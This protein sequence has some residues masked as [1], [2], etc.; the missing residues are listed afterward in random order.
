MADK[1]PPGRRQLFGAALLKMNPALAA[2]A[3]ADPESLTELERTQLGFV[4]SADDPWTKELLATATDTFMLVGLALHVRFPIAKAGDFF[5]KYAKQVTGLEAAQFPLVSKMRS[6]LNIFRGTELETLYPE[7]VDAKRL[8]QVDWSGEAADAIKRWEKRM[9]RK[10]TTQ[11]EILLYADDVNDWLSTSDIRLRMTMPDYLRPLHK[12]LHRTMGRAWHETAQGQAGKVLEDLRQQGMDFDPS[13]RR[14]FMPRQKIRQIDDLVAEAGGH[15]ESSM[16][17][18]PAEIARREAGLKKHVAGGLRTRRHVLAPST[19]DLRAVQEHLHGNMSELERVAQ[20]GQE[21]GQYS[22]RAV[23][24][25]IPKYLHQMSKTNAFTTQ[26]YGKRVVDATKRVKESG[27]TNAALLGKMMDDTYIPL[28]KNEMT[29]GQA[30][31][32]QQWASTKA[33][34]VST[35]DRML[36]QGGWNKGP[37][38]SALKSIKN[39]LLHEEGLL[40]QAGSKL[41]GLWTTGALGGNVSAALQNLSSTALLA[42]QIGPTAAGHGIRQTMKKGEKYFRVRGKKGEWAAWQE[43]FPEFSKSGLATDP[44][45]GE[46][47]ELL[48]GAYQASNKMG[49]GLGTGVKGGLRRFQQAIMTPFSA[50]EVGQRLVAFEGSHWKALKDGL[51]GQG[52]RDFAKRMVYESQFTAGPVSSP[53]MFLN[54]PGP[55][56]HL[57]TYGAR[58]VE[59]LGASSA[60]ASGGKGALGPAWGP[61]EGRSFGNLG[62]L[63]MAT[64]LMEGTGRMAGQD[65]ERFGFSGSIPFREYGAFAPMPVP[66]M[67]SMLGSAFLDIQAGEFNQMKRQIS[68]F[69][70]G[71]AAASRALGMVSPKAAM[72]LDKEYTDWVP[73]QQG[74]YT[75]FDYAGRSRGQY[76]AF[77][78]MLRAAGLPVGDMDREQAARKM[79][80]AQRDRMKEMRKEYLRLSVTGD[81]GA[82]SKIGEDWE[83]AFGF[84]L[85]VRPQD[86]DTARMHMRM[87]RNE[88]L[89]GTMPRDVQPQMRRIIQLDAVNSAFHLQQRGVD[90]NLMNPSYFWSKP[91]TPQGWSPLGFQPQGGRPRTSQQQQGSF[92]LSDTFAL[93]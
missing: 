35:I 19:D 24:R 75:L 88:S 16:G 90:P 57:M 31:W 39:S 58:F 8:K 65:W 89:I 72:A 11:D 15:F 32:A 63:A 53:Y 83:R 21:R 60:W 5:T 4:S 29:V 41:T 62:R 30:V 85:D 81:H 37:A 43:A 36:D 49:R 18:S 61:L 48:D 84:E 22:L 40:A 67:A 14:N 28:L 80:L 2:R 73:D 51:K 69:V 74:K 54:L 64:A 46:V 91:Q 44:L 78:L 7:A 6:F 20:I 86:W 76:S 12:D 42:T 56:R 38:A 13:F 47:R 59:Q 26:G 10:L 45:T 33:W 79:I 34:G 1:M 68:L 23:S 71:G 70:P 25:A 77:Q 93:P 9:G 17:I 87:A 92:E 55:M 27:G 82:A 52:A 66:P 50:G 3:L